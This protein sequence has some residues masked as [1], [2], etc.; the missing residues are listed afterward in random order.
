MLGTARFALVV[1]M[2]VVAFVSL[3]PPAGAA[4]RWVTRQGTAGEPFTFTALP[5]ALEIYEAGEQAQNLRLALVGVER[6]NAR[7]PVYSGRVP[8][9]RSIQVLPNGNLLFADRTYPMVAE[10]TRAGEEVWSYRQSDDAALS[11][12]FSAQRFTRQGVSATLIVDRQEAY[13]VFAVDG[14]KRVIW[15]YG[16]TGERG[17][18]VNHLVDPFYAMYSPEADTVLIT[19]NNGANRVIEVRW[20][21]YRAGA[22]DNGFDEQSIVWSYGEPGVRGSGPGLLEKPHCAQRLA[23]GNVL[24]TDADAARVIEVDRASKR[25]VWQYGDTDEPGPGPGRLQ[26]PNHAV[27]LSDGHTLITETGGGRVLRV[28]RG[29][30]VVKQYDVRTAGRPAGQGTGDP[31]PRAAAYTRDGLLAVA[32][33]QFQQIVLLGHATEGRAESP[34]L[35]AGPAG[36][37]KAFQSLTW[38]GDTGPAGTRI[39][40]DYRVDDGPWRACVF[41]SGLR[42]FDFPAGTVG[43]T[44]RYRVT[45]GTADRGRTPV[46]DAVVIQA[47]KPKTGGAGGGGGGA[48]GGSGNSGQ[49]GT[50]TYPPAAQGGTGTSG[51]GTGSGT[52]GAGSG[53]GVSGSGSGASGAGAGASAA[54][55][56]PDVP[57][58]SVGSGPAHPVQGFEV[59]GEEG[60]SGVPLRAEKGAQ[61][62]APER[63]GAP[64]PLL[65]LAV[66]G[67]VVV[68]AFFGPWPVVAAELRRLTG[69]DHTR[70][71]GTFPFRLLGK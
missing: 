43:K 37:A 33:S 5:D 62:P 14:Q 9:P 27:R 16:V 50:Y 54:A 25:I 35:D 55:G 56:P 47:I 44:I 3:P 46:L 59:Q 29:K 67:L 18:T 23:D 19:D 41:T 28:D 17:L 10:V 4:V 38:Q 6:V 70:P 61:A 71:T 21:D 45:L 1:A 42:R 30:N 63:P 65:A 58:D 51:T 60:V 24:I 31:D 49:T 15:Q 8:D 68:A 66:A 40:V 22:P 20:G 39:A 48:A 7:S 2:A 11:R 34:P 64:V 69:F 53:A 52:H 13:R 32:E 12:P 36:K 26:D 57:V